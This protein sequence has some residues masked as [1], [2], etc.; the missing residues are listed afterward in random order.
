MNYGLYY[1]ELNEIVG[2]FY[3]LAPNHLAIKKD[4]QAIAFLKLICYISVSS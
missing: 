1:M 3:T 2:L 4:C